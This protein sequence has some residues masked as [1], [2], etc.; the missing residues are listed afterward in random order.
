MQTLRALPVRPLDRRAGGPASAEP[1][2]VD[3]HVREAEDPKGG[4]DPLRLQVELTEV[5]EDP[6]RLVAALD[7]EPLVVPGDGGP[8]T[9]VPA[10]GEAKVSVDY[11]SRC[12]FRRMARG[13]SA[14]DSDRLLDVSGSPR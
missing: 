14:S 2:R 7:A 3:S 4:V 8:E 13:R 9:V 11:A 10:A 6:A 5:R 1:R 12:V